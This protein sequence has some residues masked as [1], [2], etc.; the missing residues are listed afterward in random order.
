MEAHG[1]GGQASYAQVAAAVGGE[2][3]ASIAS[4]ELANMGLIYKDRSLASEITLSDDGKAVAEAI[5][6]SRISGSDRRAEV[7]KAFL[8]WLADGATPGEPADFVGSELATSRQIPF[9]KDEVQQAAEA[10]AE[11]GLIRAFKAMGHPVL[12]PSITIDGR[13]AADDPRTPREFIAQGGSI[14]YNTNTT[15][16]GNGSTVGGVQT[17]G[18]GNR[19]QIS[20]RI[21]SSDQAQVLAIVGGLLSALDKADADTTDLRRAVEDIKAE[22]AGDSPT[23]DGLKARVVQALVIAGASE[24]GHLVLQGLAQLLGLTSA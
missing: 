18:Q 23:R 8:R 3:A 12:R 9:T 21:D 7:Q 14:T 10:L 1:R 4:E 6:A 2:T 22:A 16:I 20:Q 11:W 24:S 17:G 13:E 5:A 19:Q 15:T